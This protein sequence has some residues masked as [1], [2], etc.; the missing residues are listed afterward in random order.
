MKCKRRDITH[1]SVIKDRTSVNSSTNS[2]SSI[3]HVSLVECCLGI[4]SVVTT[5]FS[6][7][8][9]PSNS[10][11]VSRFMDVFSDAIDKNFGNTSR[12]KLTTRRTCLTGSFRSPFACDVR[13]DFA[14]GSGGSC[15]GTGGSGAG[16]GGT[17]G[18]GGSATGGGTDG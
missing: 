8:N 9:F 2:S 17:V 15:R 6:P 18:R 12:G 7:F 1:P 5:N 13:L 3:V 16:R 14:T 11:H 4:K 10:P